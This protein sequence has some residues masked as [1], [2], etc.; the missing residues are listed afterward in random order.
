MNGVSIFLVWLQLAFFSLDGQVR[1]SGMC[2]VSLEMMTSVVQV[3]LQY[4]G[5]A[6]NVHALTFTS[7][8]LQLHL[9]ISSSIQHL[10]TCRHSWDPPFCT[11][12][13]LLQ[14]DAAGYTAL[15]DAIKQACDVGKLSPPTLCRL[16]FHSVQI[17]GAVGRGYAAN[18]GFHAFEAEYDHPGNAGLGDDIAYLLK[19]KL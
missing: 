12:C 1:P 9:Y 11:N 16:G 18:G 15:I 4:S 10:I 13:L 7:I 2:G 3:T 5:S 14:L 17:A 6:T 19:V 8:S